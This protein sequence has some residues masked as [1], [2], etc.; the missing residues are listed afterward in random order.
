MYSNFALWQAS[1]I[2]NYISI[3]NKILLDYLEGYTHLFR[4]LLRKF[5]NYFI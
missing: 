1:N 5:R 2:E 3:T 4:G